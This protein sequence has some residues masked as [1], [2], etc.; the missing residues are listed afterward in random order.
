MEKSMEC[1]LLRRWTRVTVPIT[2]LLSLGACSTTPTQEAQEAV[3]EVV[4][5]TGEWI[6]NEDLSDSPSDVL[7]SVSGESTIGNIFRT[8]GGA[9]RVYGISVDDVVGMLPPGEEEE[10]PEYH[11]HVTDSR[12]TLIVLQSPDSMEIEY[13]RG[14]T[15]IYQNGRTTEDE[16]ERVFSDWEGTTYIVEREPD[17]GPAITEVF[18]LADDGRLLIWTIT[19]EGPKGKEIAITRVYDPV[20]ESEGEGQ[21][22]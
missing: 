15:E 8:V 11:S 19:T 13:D 9:I 16:D 3:P 10:E 1:G 4:D 20:V 7:R 2:V 5:L 6:L 14:G 21:S 12:Y 17:D 22:S 18:Q